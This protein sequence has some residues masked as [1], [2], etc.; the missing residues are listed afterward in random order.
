MRLLWGFENYEYNP[1]P[2]EVGLK[3]VVAIGQDQ[4]QLIPCKGPN[5]PL[6]QKKVE[7]RL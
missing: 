3:I 6:A 2:S 7:L 5:L 1:E 4:E